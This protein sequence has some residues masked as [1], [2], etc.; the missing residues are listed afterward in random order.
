MKPREDDLKKPDEPVLAKTMIFKDYRDRGKFDRPADDK[1][2]QERYLRLIADGMRK[3]KIDPEYIEDQI[4]G[5]D[6]EPTVKPENYKTVPAIQGPT[7]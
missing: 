5:V 2:P 7:I 4:M 1:L 3:Y 6:F